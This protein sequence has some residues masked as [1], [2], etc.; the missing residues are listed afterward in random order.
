MMALVII[1]IAAALISGVWLINHCREH[2]E[3]NTHNWTKGEIQ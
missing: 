3:P 1:G 2:E